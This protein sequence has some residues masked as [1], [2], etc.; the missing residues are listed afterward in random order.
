MDS[1]GFSYFLQSLQLDSIVFTVQKDGCKEKK[2]AEKDLYG[3]CIGCR[4]NEDNNSEDCREDASHK[5]ADSRAGTLFYDGFFLFP[6]KIVEFDVDGD[7]E[8]HRKEN[9]KSGD[10]EKTKE[11]GECRIQSKQEED[12]GE[13]VEWEHQGQ[14]KKNFAVEQG[15]RWDGEGLEKPEILPFHGD[16]YSGGRHHAEDGGKHIRKKR[17]DIHRKGLRDGV[18]SRDEDGGRENTS[19]DG[20]DN[21]IGDIDTGGEVALEF[22]EIEGFQ[23]CAG[24]ESLHLISVLGGGCEKIAGDAMVVPG[25]EEKGQEHRKDGDCEIE[26]K[27]RDA[28]LQNRFTEPSGRGIKFC[29]GVSEGRRE[30]GEKFRGEVFGGISHSERAE[31]NNDNKSDHQNGLCQAFVFHS[32]RYGGDE[33]SKKNGQDKR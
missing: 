28:V 19:H 17:G 5:T 6:V 11:F 1:D 23:K 21:G 7:S 33:C 24:F 3:D 29:D 25:D 10:E 9:D 30:V 20:P 4:S 32:G 16:G 2:E 22:A 15:F 12:F 26:K 31:Q 27:M 13:E 18:K 8:N 14:V